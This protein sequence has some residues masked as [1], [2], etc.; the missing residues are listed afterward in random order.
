M[1]LSVPL[2]LA[3]ASPRRRGLLRDLGLSFEVYPSGVDETVIAGETPDQAVERLALA[4]ALDV[5]G[6]W[7]HALTIGADTVVVLDGDMLGKPADP[8]EARE[9]LRRLSGRSNIVFTGLALVHPDTNRSVVAHERTEVSFSA[10]AENEI[11]AYVRSGAPLDKAGAYGIQG[12]LG[13]V[14]ISRIDGD[15]FN[16]VGLPLHLLYTLLKRHFGDLVTL[17]PL[18]SPAIDANG[19]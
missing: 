7:P 6:S 5:A 16:V 17:G 15:Y 12:D 11:E 14:F 13:A 2:V 19:A 8:A 18:V 9:M 4:K 3:S 10:L 1:R